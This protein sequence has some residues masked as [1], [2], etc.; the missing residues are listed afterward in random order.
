MTP[1]DIL[2]IYSYEYD[3]SNS[4]NS[5]NTSTNS[6][7]DAVPEDGKGKSIDEELYAGLNYHVGEYIISMYKAL[8]ALYKNIPRTNRS[9]E[10]FS[11]LNK[12]SEETHEIH[13]L[14]NDRSQKGQEKLVANS[15]KIAEIMKKTVGFFYDTGTG[16]IEPLKEFATREENKD[17]FHDLW[18]AVQQLWSAKKQY[19][20]IEKLLKP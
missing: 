1:Q 6:T 18:G 11:K 17:L 12:F 8:T 3:L 16:I 10:F 13:N 7:K 15:A 9:K 14:L 19:A 5:N 20:E 2:K 4:T